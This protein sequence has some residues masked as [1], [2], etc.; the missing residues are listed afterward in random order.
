VKRLLLAVAAGALAATFAVP[1]QAGPGGILHNCEGKI[2]T[3]CNKTPCYPD[4]PC[5]VTPCVI[6]KSDKCLF[7]A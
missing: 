3:A 1:A 6:W 2:D 4:Y 5:T 7:P